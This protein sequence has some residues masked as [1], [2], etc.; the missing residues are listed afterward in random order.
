MSID[1]P[2]TVNVWSTGSLFFT[3]TCTTPAFTDG[4]LGLNVYAAIDT[5]SVEC[6][7]A[8]VVV[9]VAGRTVVVVVAGRAVVVVDAGRAAV[10]GDAATDLAAVVGVSGG[11]A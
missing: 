11:M 10:V 9:V 7:G 6:D 2:V 5:A 3:V 1:V 4:W 8:A